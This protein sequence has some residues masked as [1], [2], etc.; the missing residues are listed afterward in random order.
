MKKTSYFL[1]IFLFLLSCKMPD[2]ETTQ[3]GK[4]EQLIIITD[5]LITGDLNQENCTIGNY[6]DCFAGTKWFRCLEDDK[7]DE[8]V[9]IVYFEKDTNFCTI[10]T[11]LHD[12]PENFRKF[13]FVTHNERI[14]LNSRMNKRDSV[15]QEYEYLVGHI[16]KRNILVFNLLKNGDIKLG[17]YEFK[18]IDY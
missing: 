3:D 13:E 17:C 7:D 10:H 4:S 15:N 18:K 9:E 5:T 14:F 1:V 2:D 12:H 16:D 8:F 6:S 11:L